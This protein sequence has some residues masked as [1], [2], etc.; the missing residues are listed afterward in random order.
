M[1]YGVAGSVNR[2]SGSVGTVCIVVYIVLFLY[3]LGV[4]SIPSSLAF[5]SDD[6]YIIELTNTSSSKLLLLSSACFNVLLAELIGCSWLGYR[7][8]YLLFS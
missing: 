1:S 3:D 7:W 8:F 5:L 6:N 2:L 4:D